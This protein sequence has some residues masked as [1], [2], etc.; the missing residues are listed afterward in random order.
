M[1]DACLKCG[2]PRAV[3]SAC[4]SCGALYAKVEAM[5]RE[6]RSFLRRPAPPPVLPLLQREPDY[7]LSPGRSAGDDMPTGTPAAATARLVP[8]SSCGKDISPR[9]KAC[10]HCGEERPADVPIEVPARAQRSAKQKT[11]VDLILIAVV[12][13]VGLVLKFS[14]GSTE[15]PRAFGETAAFGLCRTIIARLSRDPEKAE[16]PWVENT[17][18]GGNFR[19]TWAF[20]SRTMRMR[21]GLGLEV[22]MTGSCTVDA[23]QQRVSSLTLD[24]KVLF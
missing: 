1:P 4:P 14:G 12:I 19:F 13:G 15:P 11:R 21:N 22:P 20:N 24:G 2:H 23:S 18:E 17:G 16:I 6:G 9:A 10:P 3:A 5:A 7:S 8:C